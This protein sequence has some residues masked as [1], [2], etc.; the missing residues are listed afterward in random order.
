[1]GIK[2][3]MA[4]VAAK[5]VLTKPYR[6]FARRAL[7]H[8]TFRVWGYTEFPMDLYWNLV[9]A[10]QAKKGED[11]PGLFVYVAVDRL[12][13]SYLANHL[14][15]DCEWSHTGILDVGDENNKGW[16]TVSMT[17]AGFTR[18][19]LLEYLKMTDSFA[20]GFLPLKN[21]EAEVEARRRLA[22]IEGL[23]G[24]DAVQYDFSLQINENVLA[25]LKGDGELE[26][27]FK[28]LKIYCSEMVWM[29]AADLEADE[30]R[31]LKPHWFIDRTVVEPDDV[32][33]ALEGNF[34]FKG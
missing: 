31:E 1:M 32:A 27:G 15:S 12:A 29:V 19:P 16:A 25:W 5:V 34:L 7:A 8:F 10:V 21:E 33:E 4:K 6:W 14:F 11:K 23:G 18:K 2:E 24:G 22:K 9:D 20:V 30:L 17:S 13:L 26:E 28:P 3:W